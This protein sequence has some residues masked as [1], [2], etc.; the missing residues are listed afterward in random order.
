[1][2]IELLYLTYVAV[3]TALMW[4]PYIL[5][6]IVV[7]GIHDAVGYPQDSKPLAAWATRLKAAHY[8]AVANKNNSQR[9]LAP[10]RMSIV[11]V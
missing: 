7:R 2:A 8:N 1:M 3:F 5:N 10:K 11:S 6:T 9:C 4:L